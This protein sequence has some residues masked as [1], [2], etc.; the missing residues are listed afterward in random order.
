MNGQPFINQGLAQAINGGTL[1]FNNSWSNSGTLVQSGG[2]LYLNGNMTTAGLVTINRTNGTVYL[3]GVLNNTNATL[4]LNAASGS[5]VLSGGT[6]Q[7]GTIAASGGAGL[8]VNN[9][10]NNA[11]VGVTVSGTLDVGNSYN[12][13]MVNVTGGLVLSNATVLVGNPTN[14]WSGRLWFSGSQ[15]LGGTGTV[16]FGSSGCNGLVVNNDGTTLTIG[17]GVTVR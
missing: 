11:L 12:N 4:A 3:T 2:T 8:L 16:V 17:P 15:T 14:G 10:G 13:G 1:T 5:W 9:N 6:V 7:G